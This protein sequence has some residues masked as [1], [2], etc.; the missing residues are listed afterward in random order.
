MPARKRPKMTPLIVGE[1]VITNEAA[2]APARQMRS[3]V[4]RPMRLESLTMSGQHTI[5]ATLKAEVA[6]PTCTALAPKP[7][8]CRGMLEIAMPSPSI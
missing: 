2:V 1:R 6:K 8:R 3:T 5:C 4:V 7:F